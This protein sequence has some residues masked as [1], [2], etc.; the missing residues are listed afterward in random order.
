MS[1]TMT[2]GQATNDDVPSLVCGYRSCGWCFVSVQWSIVAMM[3]EFAMMVPSTPTGFIC[4]PWVPETEP[5]V[6]P[7]VAHHWP[8]SVGSGGG[9]H[10]KQNKSL[11][12]KSVSLGF[13]Y[14][15]SPCQ[16]PHLSNDM[17]ECA[18][19]RPSQQSWNK[20]MGSLVRD[21]G[22]VV[23]FVAQPFPFSG[24]AAQRWL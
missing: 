2:K 14:G 10:K 22:D 15:N 13:A 11:R 20:W 7:H 17:W 6:N 9:Q 24:T 16:E 12:V 4:F 23:L 5:D 19:Y 3:N 21:G 8:R 18:F 1:V